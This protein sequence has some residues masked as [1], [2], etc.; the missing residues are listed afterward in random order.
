MLMKQSSEALTE[1]RIWSP[2]AHISQLDGVR[3]LAILLVT[4]FR[5]GKSFP[6]DTWLG[7]TIQNCLKFGDR[8]VELFFV[9]SGFLITGILIDSKSSSNFFTNFFARRSL[10]IFPL[11]FGSLALLLLILPSLGAAKSEFAPAIDQ[12]VFLWTYLTNVQMSL[13]NEWCFGPLDHFWSLAVEE[14]FYVLWPFV[15]YFCS[16]ASALRCAVILAGMS[17]LSRVGL[18][19]LGDNSVAFDVLSIFRFDALL[20]G[21][22]IALLIRKPGGLRSLLPWTYVAFPALVGV[23]L[24]VA[25]WDLKSA[26]VLH[27]IVPLAWACLLIWLVESRSTGFLARIFNSPFLQRLGKFSYAMYVFQSPLIPLTAS[28]VSVAG[29]T[30]LL[31]SSLAAGIFYIIAM[32]VLTYGAAVLS[33]YTVERHFLNLKRL[34]QEKAVSSASQA[35][36]A[37]Y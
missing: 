10:R 21:A 1:A 23:C 9:L 15:I 17:A 26:T 16:A 22:I 2:R 33:W 19:I 6:D 4:L 29:L 35:P 30:T 7:S 12:Q 5:F 27:T 31:G 24:A 28:V 20:V 18:A 11:Y 13:Q 37:A 25:V 14:H 32:F 36:A 34:F 8:G 3:G